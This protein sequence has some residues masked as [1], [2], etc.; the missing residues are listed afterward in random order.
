MRQMVEEELACLFEEG[1][2]EPVQLPH[3]LHQLYL[4]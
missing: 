4:C 2:L 1:T 3:G